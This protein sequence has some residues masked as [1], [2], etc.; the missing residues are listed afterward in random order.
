MNDKSDIFSNEILQ[1]IKEWESRYPKD[2]KK[3]VIIPA[4]HILQDDN[5]GYLTNELIRKLAMYLNVNVIDVFEV[6]T[7][8]SMY[9]LEK[10]GKHKINVCNNV[11][12]M[13]KGSDEILKFLEKKLKVKVGETTLD[14]AVT[15]RSVECQGVCCNAPVLEVDKVLYKNIEIHDI[16]KIINDLD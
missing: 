3:S 9:D 14:G 16:E 10:I 12:C 15:L 2:Q 1:R 8:Y 6:A 13:L 5:G 7:F 11:S 4:L